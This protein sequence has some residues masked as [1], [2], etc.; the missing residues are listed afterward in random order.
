VRDVEIVTAR[1]DAL[2]DAVEERRP[3]FDGAPA[4][5]MRDERRA[6]TVSLLSDVACAHGGPHHDAFALVWL[7]H[8]LLDLEHAA[9][10]LVGPVGDLARR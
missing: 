6:M 5:D 2:A 7:G 9:D 10:D 4:G 1:F 8:W 3:V